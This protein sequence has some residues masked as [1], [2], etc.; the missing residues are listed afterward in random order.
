MS[1][2]QPQALGDF[3]K[4]ETPTTESTTVQPQTPVVQEIEEIQIDD[5]APQKDGEVKITAREDA[6]ATLDMALTRR[7]EKT[8]ALAQ[9]MMEQLKEAEIEETLQAEEASISEKE[10]PVQEDEVVDNEI[11]E[12][13]NGVITDD[14]FDIDLELDDD[15]D[16][17]TPTE[18][19]K[20]IEE[21]E[22]KQARQEYSDLI[23]NTVKITK[24]IDLG[25]FKIRKTPISITKALAQTTPKVVET[26]TVASWVL[27]ETKNVFT[28]SGLTGQEIASIDPEENRMTALEFYRNKFS[29]I[30]NHI[31]GEKPSSL[32]AWMKTIYAGDYAHLIFGVYR[33]TFGNSNHIAMQCANTAKD[34]DGKNVCGKVFMYTPDIESMINHKTEKSKAL[35]KELMLRGD[36][37][38]SD[39]VEAN[40]VQISDN[41]VVALKRPS[42]YTIFIENSIFSE[43]ERQKHT[44]LLATTSY[45]D[46]IYLI[47]TET[48]SL[49]PIDLKPDPNSIANT[50]KRKL[51]AYIKIFKQL[52]PDQ[53]SY[54]R[55]VVAKIDSDEPESE[56]VLP[57]AVCP[58]CGTIVKSTPHSP[59]NMLFTRHR[60]VLYRNS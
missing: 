32:E 25:T 57:D 15:E 21:A 16:D 9:P 41:Y 13:D 11:D 44:K 34:K 55:V 26:E 54:L 50:V 19:N 40:L 42:L 5:I 1:E 28:M 56:Y 51:A 43:A 30:Y 12:L 10:K 31:K 36:G 3:L 59:L 39:E 2:Q 48:Q 33:A 7:K 46:S 27:P 22:L 29:I 24:G 49:I 17:E 20:E 8:I 52:T 58:H 14:E 18:N 60:L 38:Y 23:A 35:F 53:Y 6:L 4:Q 47:N 37:I 45:I